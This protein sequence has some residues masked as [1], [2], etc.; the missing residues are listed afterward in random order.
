M[1]GEGEGTLPYRK[2]HVLDV[3]SL[4]ATFLNLTD[5]QIEILHITVLL[6]NQEK[7]NSLHRLRRIK[8]VEKLLRNLTLDVSLTPRVVNLRLY[9]QAVHHFHTLHFCKTIHICRRLEA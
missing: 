6:F 3:T 7:M 8:S 9:L 1:R 2:P 4:S 5:I